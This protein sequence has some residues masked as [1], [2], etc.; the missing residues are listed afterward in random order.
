[1]VKVLRLND[2]QVPSHKWNNYI[3]LHPGRFRGKKGGR[4]VKA[5]RRGAVVNAGFQA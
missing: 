1:M 4:N 2:C 3:L 5:K